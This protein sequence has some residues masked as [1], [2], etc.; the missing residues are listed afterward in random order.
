MSWYGDIVDFVRNEIELG[1]AVRD[2]R[3][4]L[5][6]TQATLAEKAQVS[7]AYVIT[8][9]QGAGARAE[10]GRA[11]RVIRALGAQLALVPDPTPSYSDA[12]TQLLDRG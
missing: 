12:L 1:Q 6:W 2:A 7:R 8:L 5:G 9:E 3:K 11:L 10:L 4:G